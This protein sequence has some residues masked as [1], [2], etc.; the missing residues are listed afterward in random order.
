MV[1]RYMAGLTRARL[2]PD[3][4][5]QI[6][7]LGLDR[8][9]GGF[10]GSSRRRKAPATSYDGD[11]LPALVGLG[12]PDWDSDRVWVWKDEGTMANAMATSAR[13]RR[14][15]TGRAPASSGAGVPAASV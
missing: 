2:D 7:R 8:R 11:G 5:S 9:K 3:R 10:W 14:A 6:G 4:Q 1:D 15:G 12:H 13:S